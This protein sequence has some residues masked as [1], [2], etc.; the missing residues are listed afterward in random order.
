M[1]NLL[2]KLFVKDHIH[3]EKS[4]VRERYGVFSSFVGVFVNLLPK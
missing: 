2:I 4:E 3:P 1:T